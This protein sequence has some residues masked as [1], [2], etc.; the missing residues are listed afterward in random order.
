M[1]IYIL[2]IP[3]T[4]EDRRQELSSIICYILGEKPIDEQDIRLG[5]NIMYAEPVPAGV[6]CIQL[7]KVDR[8]VEGRLR[9]GLRSFWT[10]LS[11][12]E[13]G[14]Y[15]VSL[16]HNL[17][18]RTLMYMSD[19]SVIFDKA[20][21]VPPVTTTANYNNGELTLEWESK[22]IDKRT[23]D[24]PVTVEQDGFCL[25][26]RKNPATIY[27]FGVPSMRNDVDGNTLK[28]EETE[29]KFWRII[30]RVPNGPEGDFTLPGFRQI[31]EES[32][33]KIVSE[34]LR[35]PQTR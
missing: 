28:Y 12:G 32:Y 8:V 4:M 6:I 7:A 14:L 24:Q 33:R 21:A 22:F 30:Q 20:R 26:A 35:K 2:S 18:V 11:S 19:I 23:T 16:D 10:V 9:D 1:F 34:R 3:H 27:L 31:D 15:Q 25:A 13:R 17:R 5:I 29:G